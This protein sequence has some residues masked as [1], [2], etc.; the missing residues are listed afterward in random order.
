MIPGH[1]WH[2]DEQRNSVKTFICECGEKVQ[3]RSYIDSDARLVA[4]EHSIEV[5]YDKLEWAVSFIDDVDVQTQGIKET[6]ERIGTV[7]QEANHWAS[8]LRPIGPGP[9]MNPGLPQGEINRW[10]EMIKA[11]GE[12][13][14]IEPI[15]GV[16]E[17]YL[18]DE[19]S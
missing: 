4:L 11:T 12:E 17:I 10:L 3:L 1:H 6:V 18:D 5:L 8:M 13:L 15:V 19:Q 2:V 16:Q 9:N 14:S 7:A